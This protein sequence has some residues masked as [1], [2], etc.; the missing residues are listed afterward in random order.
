MCKWLFKFRRHE[1]ALFQVFWWH[2]FI[3]K[4]GIGKV[5][6]DWQNQKLVTTLFIFWE[7]MVGWPS[8][9]KQVCFTRVE[10]ATT[11]NKVG[12]WES[13]RAI[14]EVSVQVSPIFEFQ[15]SVP[16]MSPP[17][18]SKSRTRFRKCRQKQRYFWWYN[19]APSKVILSLQVVFHCKRA[20]DC[21]KFEMIACPK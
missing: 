15:Q 9:S 6:I 4:K 8:N 7:L 19:V 12:K 21:S 11:G 3:A 16:L 18:M 10:D 1:I 20:N 17:E 5:W 2:G 14:R 13:E